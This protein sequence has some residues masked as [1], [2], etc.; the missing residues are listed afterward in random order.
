MITLNQ[1]VDQIV[2]DVRHGD[3]LDLFTRTV[4]LQYELTADETE[5]IVNRVMIEGPMAGLEL[6]EF[7]LVT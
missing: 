4:C 5:V 6:D 2:E 7:S 1:I 3:Y